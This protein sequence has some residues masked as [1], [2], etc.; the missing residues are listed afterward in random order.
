MD[1]SL[2]TL[3]LLCKLKVH[4]PKGIFLLRGNHESFDGDVGKGGVPQARLLWQHARSLRGKKYARQLAECFD[5]LAYL[6]RSRDFVACHAGPPRRKT[7]FQ[8]L[9]DLPDDPRLAREILWGRLRRT[10][11]P[12]G[13]AKRDVKAFREAVGARKGTPF[14]VSH[15]PLSRTGT[16]W[17]DAGDIPGHHILYS[18]NPERLAVF[19]RSGGTMIPLEFPGEPLLDFVNDLETE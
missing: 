9:I 11:R 6:A 8:N 16:I 3:D 14:I 18:A 12:D 13:Y 10:G 19:V 4:F 15:T 7:S 17:T 2:L 1:S 5:L